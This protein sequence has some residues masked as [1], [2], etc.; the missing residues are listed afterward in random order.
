MA[1]IQLIMKFSDIIINW[2]NKNARNLPWRE[3]ADPYKIWISEIILQQTRVNQGL[4]FYIRFIKRFPNIE[5][6]AKAKEQE[7]LKL[8]QGLGYY[9][10]ARNLHFTAK[11]IVDNHNSTF[12]SDYKEILN[13]KGV[14]DYTAAAI[15]SFCYNLPYAVLDGNVIRVLSRYY[16]MEIA[17]DSSEGKTFLKRKAEKLLNNDNPS[18]YNQAIMEFGALQCI[19]RSPDCNICPLQTSCQSFGTELVN[20]LPI[21][22][23]SIKIKKRYFNYLI[24][25]SGEF[26]FIQK[27]DVGIWRSLFEFP[28]IEGDL[29]L[30]QI[31]RS[32]YWKK[33]FN[34]HSVLITNIS[35]RIKHQLSHQIIFST[36]IHVSVNQMKKN[37]LMKIKWDD[38]NEYPVPRLIDKY[39]TQII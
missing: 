1:N 38:L 12:P 29:N 3:T 36:F 6:L 17:V 35:G 24:I 28:L 18:Q 15:A 2:Y 27:R 20:L 14:G 16:A 11:Y 9:S 34:S 10:R 33:L 32:E 13:L 25:K 19:K 30:D 21:K 7:V 23:K 37:D 26:T 39:L 5:L 22:K 4:P 8:W 31:K